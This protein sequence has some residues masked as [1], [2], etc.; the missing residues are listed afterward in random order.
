[1]ALLLLLLWLGW[2][3]RRRDLGRRLLHR[4]LGDRRL[5]FARRTVRGR[6]SVG[7]GVLRGLGGSL[8]LFFCLTRGLLFLLLHEL[9][10]ALLFALGLDHGARLLEQRTRGATITTHG[11]VLLELLL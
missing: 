1:L 11:E 8:R 3:R 2:R 6:G 10:H 7:R 9:E 4:L 5:A